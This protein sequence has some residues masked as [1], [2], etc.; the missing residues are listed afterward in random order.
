MTS[1]AKE[2]K[3]MAILTP[4]PDWQTNEIAQIKE[5]WD[6]AGKIVNVVGPPLFLGQWWVPI[7]WPD[8]EDPDFIK[9]AALEKPKA[10]KTPVSDQEKIEILLAACE[11]ICNARDRAEPYGGM[12]FQQALDNVEHARD[13]AKS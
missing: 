10:Q 8:M 2:H 4:R 5:K 12:I 9:A 13:R 3:K 1:K 7:L 11:D 6:G